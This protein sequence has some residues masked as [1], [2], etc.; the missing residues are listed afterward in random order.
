MAGN[1]ILVH[2]LFLI[3]LP[4]IVAYYGLSTP[5]AAALV[6]LALL[7]RLSITLSVFL[8]PAKVPE[9]E[10]ETITISHFA[11][12]V[13]WCMDRLGVE[14]VERQKAAIFGVFFTGRTV[15]QLKV[16]SGLT[17]SM[18]G[19]SPDILRFLY[20]RY[21]AEAEGKAEFLAPDA[22]RLELERRIDRYGAHLQVWVYY[23]I[24][25][26]RALALHAWGH[27]HSAVPA[28]QRALLPIMF[29]LF[30]GFLRRAFRINDVNY[31]KALG[32]IEQLLD[33][34]EDMLSDGRRSLLGGD[35]SDYVDISMAS[36]SALW[37]QP[38]E[39]AAGRAKAVRIARADFPIKMSVDVERWIE[40]YP[41]TKAFVERLYREERM[42]S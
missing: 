5:G 26:D 31:G 28:W 4:V 10:L 19:N 12:K 17:R 16:H 7:W 13:R 38:D 6:V 29:P 22:G 40:K 20:G 3:A 41:L 35:V 39:F 15:P 30:R 24:L 23:H 2:S 27:D 8:F 9:L 37:L 11:E 18:I 25:N 32:R 33:D 36:I 14:Y 42:L 34:V 1:R 21:C